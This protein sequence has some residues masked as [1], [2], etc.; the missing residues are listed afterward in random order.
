MKRLVILITALLAPLWVFGQ[1][2]PDNATEYFEQAS[3]LYSGGTERNYF[4]TPDS[5][6]GVFSWDTAATAPQVA[7]ELLGQLGTIALDRAQEQGLRLLQTRLIAQLEEATYTVEDAERLLFENTSRYLDSTTLV[8]AVNAPEIIASNLSEDITRYAA[9]MLP[10]Y[11]ESE[12]FRSLLES[13]LRSSTEIAERGWSS[14]DAQ[15]L[16]AHLSRLLRYSDANESP[17]QLGVRLAFAYYFA[18]AE[19]EEYANGPIDAFALNIATIREIAEEDEARYVRVME[20]AALT[21]RALTAV[22]PDESRLDAEVPDYEERSRAYVSLLFALGAERAGD[23]RERKILE[24]FHTVTIALFDRRYALAVQSVAEVYLSASEPANGESEVSKGIALL[25]A[26]ARYSE[27]YVV[28]RAQS[29]PG[30]E[31]L[32]R[33]RKETLESLVDATTQRDNRSG[34]WVWSIGAEVGAGWA[35]Q[36]SGEP[37]GSGRESV[38]TVAAMLPIGLAVQ[39][40]PGESSPF[41]LHIMGYPI[42]LGQYVFLQEDALDLQPVSWENAI[43]LGIRAGV[44][45]SLGSPSN[46]LLLSGYYQYSPAI[47]GRTDDTDG[48]T[49]Y[50]VAIS[51]YVPFFDMN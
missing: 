24:R 33:L 40:L 29:D 35:H 31:E 7:N 51:Y 26:I 4:Q 27:L 36:V 16:A 6:R 10:E 12:L 30:I 3:Q 22:R 13:L 25:S 45:V 8:A 46:L 17:V 49:Q 18:S 43:T 5:A 11:T 14:F 9:A 28:R 48:V 38:H 32:A 19:N 44:S 21:Y 34:D 15:L 20:I 37:G 47:E 50:G 42:E 2:T 1:E 41:G 39:L 23:D